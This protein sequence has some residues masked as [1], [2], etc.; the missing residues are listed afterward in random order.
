MSDLDQLCE[1]CRKLISERTI[2]AMRRA[3]KRGAAIGRPRL[4][5]SER[6]LRRVRSG[7]LSAEDL[8]RELGCSTITIRRR[9]RAVR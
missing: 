6:D 7:K 1:R 8:A 4:V 2:Q 3:A 9:L 5:I